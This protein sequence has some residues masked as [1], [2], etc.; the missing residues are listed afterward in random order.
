MEYP[1]LD[2]LINSINDP[3]TKVV[4]D[5][6]ETVFDCDMLG[7]ITHADG[8]TSGFYL[9]NGRWRFSEAL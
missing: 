5:V 9:H 8:T 1:T 6:K 7:E 2:A 4:I 3:I